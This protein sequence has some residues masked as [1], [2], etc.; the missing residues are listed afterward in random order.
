[1]RA[2]QDVQRELDVPLLIG[3]PTYLGLR[4]EVDGRRGRYVWDHHY[5]SVY[6]V[7]GDG[8][9]ARYDKVHLTPFGEEIPYL[10]AWPWLEQKL[11]AMAA[12]GMSLTLDGAPRIERL[13]VPVPGGD[14]LRIGTPICFE[15]SMSE[16]CRRMVF[17]GGEKQID[18]LVNVSN[19]GWYGVHDPGRAQHA[20]I[21][22][23]RAI[24]NRVPLLRCVNTGHS[25]GIAPTGKVVAALG[26]GR[27]G[28]A[29]RSGW[30]RADL[31]LCDQ[32]TIFARIGNVFGWA[33]VLACVLILLSTLYRP[34]LGWAPTT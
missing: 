3:A 4:V 8:P 12:G 32:V 25:V 10:S 7:V 18:L 19:D 9:Y 13:A 16:L 6:V 29:R 23:F 31:P 21:S 14:P 22:R 34:R 30:V 2:V 33:C 26:P 11:S 24:E 5:N 28:E 15:D 17:A 27:Y 20:Q 1:V